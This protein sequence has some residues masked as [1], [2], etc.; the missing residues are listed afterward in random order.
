MWNCY[1]KSEGGNVA[2]MFS[3][4]V[5]TCGMF[6]G[7]A[8][9]GTRMMSTKARAQSIA[10]AAALAG[11]IA[12]EADDG[13][14]MEIVRAYLDANVVNLAPGYLVGEPTVV[15]DDTTEKVTVTIPAELNLSFGGLFGRSVQ[16]IGSDSTASYLL[17]NLDP[18]SIAFALDV[19]GSMDDTTSDGRK[20]IE[21]L[22]S[23]TAGLFRAIEAGTNE[24]DKLRNVMRTGMSAYNTEL[25]DTQ[26]MYWGWRHL[27]SSVTALYADG[28]TDSSPALQNSYTQLINDRAVRASTD[29]DFDQSRLQEYMIFMTDGNNNEPEFDQESIKLCNEI[30][31]AG[32]SLYSV[33]FD[34]EDIG[35]LLLVECASPNDTSVEDLRPKDDGSRCLSNGRN[36]N[37]LALGHCA[38]RSTRT[39]HYFDAS[40]A[41]A[42]E[43]AFE[44]IGEDIIRSNVRLN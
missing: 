38:D 30:K 9:D 43:A 35:E 41:K 22:K 8:I 13:D 11:A 37:G 31:D 25:V 6:L 14:R 32:I 26:P 7:L 5:V 40:N 3:A 10:D 2:M 1:L 29:P 44:K 18:V 4:V 17:N 28:G 19:S 27:E 34:A 42:F 36:G 23:A 12:S 24:P 16:S 39:Q 21:V 15:F 20:K 33:A